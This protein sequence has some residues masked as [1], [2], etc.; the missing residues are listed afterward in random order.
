MS[1]TPHFRIEIGGSMSTITADGRRD[2]DL[3]QDLLDLV[4][5]A[6][7]VPVRVLAE[8]AREVFHRDGAVIIKAPSR[9]PEALIDTAAAM[10]GTRL[11][12]LFA[13]RPQGGDHA[14]QLNLHSDGAVLTVD[15]HG[16]AVKLR[17]PDEDYLFMRCATPA[18]QGGESFMVDGYRLLDQLATGLPELHA[19]LTRVDID[20]FGGWTDPGRGTA[21]TPLVRR[22]V[23]YTRAGRRIVRASDYAC[24]VPREPDWESHEEHLRQYADVLATCTAATPRFRLDAGEILAIDNYRFLHGRDGYSGTRLMHV[25][26]VLSSDAM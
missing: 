13:I 21:P 10:L 7:F 4:R 3:R 1:S 23:E 22:L 25:L 6:G 5:P 18:P 2:G 26:T 12:Q 19:F 14:D 8:H 17:D 16:R 24:P 11:R 20:Y 9:G 15:V